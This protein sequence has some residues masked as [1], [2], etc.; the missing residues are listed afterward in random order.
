MNR[1]ASCSV[2]V[3]VY[4]AAGT[5]GPLCERLSAVLPGVA[6]RHEIVLVNDASPDA[7]WAVIRELA[8]ARAEVRG[9]NLTRNFGQHAALLCGI[10]A[11]TGDVIVT[12]DDDLQHPPE[13]IPRLL[14]ALVEGV[15]VVYGTPR[16]EARELWRRLGSGLIRRTL[17]VAMGVDSALRASA[18]RAF[19]RELR[20]G[21]A[22]FAS[23]YVSIDVLLSWSTARFTA[24]EVAH[25]PRQQGRSNY[26]LRRLVR[27]AWDMIT[28]FSTAP[29]QLASFTGFLFTCFGVLVLA[30]VVGR[31]L[32]LGGSVPG[33]PFIASIIAIFSGVQLFTLGIIGQYLGRV[34]Q[35]ALSRPPYVVRETVD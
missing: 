15:D 28:G 6:A 2:V 17:R 12:M 33:F 10:R 1:V 3:P 22:A 30:W 4:R 35:R 34:H 21:F 9:V 29:L 16:E 25:N 18:F 8:R 7:S 20:D 14:E 32:V 27:H 13:E 31:Y 23:P 26:T 19:R 5:V 24:V 11:A